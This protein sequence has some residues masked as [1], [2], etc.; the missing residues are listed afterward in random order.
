[1]TASAAAA[2]D[3]AA[4]GS[5]VVLATDRE[6]DQHAIALS[7]GKSLM[8]TLKDDGAM[9]IEA[10]CGG[11]AICGTCHVYVDPDWYSRLPEPG[12]MEAELLDQLVL[13]KSNS[14][15]ACQIVC[16]PALS[17]LLVTLA[18]QE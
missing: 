18:P 5:P 7:L 13:A 1:M 10:I 6:G 4:M 12:E 2:V 9:D 8:R 11:N 3:T 15:L 14:R 16:E 17:G